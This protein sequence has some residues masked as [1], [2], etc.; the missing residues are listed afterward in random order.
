MTRLYVVGGGL[1]GLAAAIEGCRLGLSVTL[2]EASGHLGGRCRSFVDARLGRRIDNGNHLLLAGNIAAMRY[3]SRTG[4]ECFVRRA[5]SVFPCL[6]LEN[7]EPFAFGFAS[8]V[9]PRL[10]PKTGVGALARDAWR[11]WRAPADSV[12]ADA[13]GASPARR[14]LW[15]PLVVAVMNA[16][17]SEAAV[18]PFRRVLAEILPKGPAGLAPLLFP[19]GLSAALVDPALDA[20][21]AAGADLRRNT[22]VGGLDVEDGR[23][24]AL[25]TRHGALPLSRD[26]MLVLAVPPAEAARL[27]P[28]LV[29]PEGVRGI[30]NAHFV[31]DGPPPPWPFLGL[32]GGT[33][34]WLFWRDGILSVTVSAADALFALDEVALI[35]RLWRDVARATGRVQDNPPPCR[36]I[37][38]KTATFHQ[39][40]ANEARRPAGPDGGLKNLR[41]AGDWTMRG[42]PATIEGS[43][44]S[45][46]RAARG[47]ASRGPSFRSP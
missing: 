23:V 25:Q 5:P 46:A 36:L 28:G 27:V 30:L 26:D 45:G 11:L 20:L 6:D 29:V 15:E 4:G 47:L 12:L 9:V 32:V 40:P 41:L 2:V 31:L 33:A 24:R 1:A 17:L 38:E 13:L 44:R 19:A 3:L 8:A 7:G 42:L 18:A 10:P 37:R 43:L 14:R 34:E 39:T 16:P 22:R 35:D 21:V